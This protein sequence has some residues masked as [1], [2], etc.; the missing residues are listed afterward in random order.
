VRWDWYS[1][2][3]PADPETVKSVV[4]A[5][6]RA[7]PVERKPRHGYDTGVEFVRD[8]LV[9]ALANLGGRSAGG[10]ARRGER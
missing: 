4:S 6:L 9:V 3:Q 10:S 2:S 7:I 8:G 1:I 5:G